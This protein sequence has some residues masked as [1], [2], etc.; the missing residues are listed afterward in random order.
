[1][2]LRAG[3]NL[4]YGWVIPEFTTTENVSIGFSDIIHE[5]PGHGYDWGI[6]A[7]LGVTVVVKPITLEPFVGG[8]YRQ[9]HAWMGGTE[10]L[11][12]PAVFPAADTISRNEWLVTSGL[13][14]LFNL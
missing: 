9:F 10:F 7:S 3:L 6:M 2:T 12:G 13:S 4:F 5:D 11:T 1:V 14:I 8:G